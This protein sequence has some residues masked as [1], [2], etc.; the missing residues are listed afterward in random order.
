MLRKK[1]KVD[2]VAR[3][4]I[5][6]LIKRNKLQLGVSFFKDKEHLL[7]NLTREN[8]LRNVNVMSCE[9]L[10]KEFVTHETNTHCKFAPIVEQRFI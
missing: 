5:D 10:A 7:R 8:V 9:V 2:A 3:I 6:F 4:C 1:H